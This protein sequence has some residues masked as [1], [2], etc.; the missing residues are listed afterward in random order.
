MVAC[1]PW[2]GGALKR[3]VCWRDILRRVCRTGLIG[4][5]VVAVGCNPSASKQA[6]NFLVRAG[7]QKITASEYQ[8]ALELYKIAYPDDA[9][10][11]AAEP[12][13]VRLDLLNELGEELVILNRAAELGLTISDAELEAAVEAVK[14]DYPPG[15]FEQTLLESAIPYDTWKKRLRVRLLV[16][17]TMGADLKSE[18]PIS[19]EEVTAYYNQH[20]RGQASAAKTDDEFQKLK[21]SILADLKQK[22]IED[23]YGEWIGRLQ[24]KY[25]V[26]I[27]QALW[28]QVSK[29]AAAGA[30]AAGP[31]TEEKK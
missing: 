21:A 11:G 13:D 15:V 23:A 25:P 29:P 19:A 7:E 5:A 6:E 17:K 1:R 24:E 27:N 26:E 12:R 31:V 4:A 20:Y 8:G 9:G 18:T 14:R 22:R 2:G 10:M 30:G 16:E 28:E 3:V